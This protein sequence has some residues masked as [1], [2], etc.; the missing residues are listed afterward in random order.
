MTDSPTMSRHNPL[1][2]DALLE[3]VDDAIADGDRDDGN[4]GV[5][6]D[7]VA[8]RL[9][10]A[11]STTSCRLAD[12]YRDGKLTRVWGFHHKTGKPRMSYLPADDH[13]D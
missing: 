2:D 8:A 10:I 6:P 3:A 11:Q 4:A 7:A 13:D 1:P 5:G 9:P 12:L